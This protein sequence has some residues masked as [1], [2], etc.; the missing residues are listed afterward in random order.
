VDNGKTWTTTYSQTALV[1]SRPDSRGDV[2][3]TTGFLFAAGKTLKSG[4]LNLPLNVYLVPGKYG[5]R[6]GVSMGWNGKSR[7]EMRE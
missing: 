2:T 5:L 4:K 7:Y 6:F 1:E 3:F